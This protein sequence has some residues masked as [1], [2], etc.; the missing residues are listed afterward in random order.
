MRKYK[1]F[2]LELNF[3]LRNSSVRSR[4]YRD[5]KNI[6]KLSNYASSA[7]FTLQ[8]DYCALPIFLPS[9]WVWFGRFIETRL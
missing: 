7:F 2:F 6:L 5:K 9:P 4:R 8:D 1:I 3:E